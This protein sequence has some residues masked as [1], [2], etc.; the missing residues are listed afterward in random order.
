MKKKRWYDK[1][2]D[3]A[4]HLE[5]FKSMDKRHVNRILK[6]LVPFARSLQPSLFEEHLMEFPLD[7]FRRRWYDE[8]PYLWNV[9]NG[10]QYAHDTTI[11]KVITFLDG[12]R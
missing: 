12:Q 7:L 8:D 11:A 2:K 3:L 6:A 1:H 9:V 10:L 5:A 4:E